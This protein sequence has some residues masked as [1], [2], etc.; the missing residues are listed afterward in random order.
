M[1]PEQ[2]LPAKGVAHPGHW[3][4]RL[5]SGSSRTAKQWRTLGWLR[6][7][8]AFALCSYHPSEQMACDNVPGLNLV[9]ASVSFGGNEGSLCDL[10][11]KEDSPHHW[12]PV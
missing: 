5:W 8:S 11:W 7:G 4:M 6:G 3:H 1:S 12:H 2:V 10:S 9:M